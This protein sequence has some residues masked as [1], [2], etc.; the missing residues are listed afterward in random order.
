MIAVDPIL[1]RIPVLACTAFLTLWTSGRST[2]ALPFQDRHTARPGSIE[3]GGSID[4]ALASAKESGLPVVVV[5]GAVW[6]PACRRFREGTIAGPEVRGL[7]ERFHW[8]YIDIDRNV[9]LAR[10]YG[11]NATPR[12]LVLRPDGTELAGASGAFEPTTYRDFLEA[13]VLGG[14][15]THEADLEDEDLTRLTWSPRGYRGLAVCFSHVGY[16]PLDLPS[17]APGQVLRLGLRPRTPSTLAQGQYEISWTESFANIFAFEEN[18]FRLDYLTV[19]S[20]LAVTYGITDTLQVEFAF[21]NLARTDSYLDPITDAFHDLFGLGDAGRD[22]F[23]E[24]DNVIDLEPRDGVQIEDRDSGSEA[25]NLALTLQH[26]LTCGSAALPAIAYAA[27]VRWD[28]GGHADLRGSSH[29]SAGLSA[30]AAR[31]LGDSFYAYLG[32]GYNWHGVDES[33]GLPLRDEQ[34]S[35]LGALEWRYAANCSWVLQYLVSEGVAVDR[36]PF[37]KP[38]NELNLGWKWEF[39]KGTVFEVGLIENIIEVD[40]SP[41]FGL[42]FGIQHR[43]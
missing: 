8:V 32:L 20:N 16:G 11:V 3:F 43:F 35:G 2:W 17:Q 36:E 21:G 24:H 39:R 22:M 28:A 12:T 10:R 13:A 15:R 31:R 41:D 25:S 9:S 29:F 38:A 7:A 4:L 6:C 14:V 5:F 18:D 42:H 34:W 27:S 23:P 26:N 1:R 40:N 33:R 37:D 19:N 30:S